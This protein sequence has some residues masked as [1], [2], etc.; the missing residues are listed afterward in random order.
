MNVVNASMLAQGVYGFF[1]QNR[2]L[3]YDLMKG[4]GWSMSPHNAKKFTD[5]DDIDIN[6]Q[7]E[8]ILSV[9]EESITVS[10]ASTSETSIV[11]STPNPSD[12]STEVSSE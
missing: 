2:D 10:S 6:A 12:S 4:E 9:A 8:N 5:N 3:V 7:I 11:V 1:A